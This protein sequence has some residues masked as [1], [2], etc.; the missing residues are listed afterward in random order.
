MRDA[1]ASVEDRR[2]RPLAR[3]RRAQED[4]DRHP[5]VLAAHPFVAACARSLTPVI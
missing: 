2:L 1:E 4:D 3:P 5:P